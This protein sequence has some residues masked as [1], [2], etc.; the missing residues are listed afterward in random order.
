VLGVEGGKSLS[1][2]SEQQTHYQSNRWEQPGSSRFEVQI[3]GSS[4]ITM[5]DSVSSL[6]Q[7][8]QTAMAPRSRLRMRMTSS[9]FDRNI[10]PSPILPVEAAL[11]MASTAALT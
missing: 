5:I 4:Q 11:T 6:T 1:S 8:R 7:N 10:F 3:Q 9:I 2:R